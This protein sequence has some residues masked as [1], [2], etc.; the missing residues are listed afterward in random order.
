[1]IDYIYGSIEPLIFYL[2]DT[3]W[4]IASPFTPQRFIDE[5]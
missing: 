3:N 5:L 1:M 2:A 4:Q